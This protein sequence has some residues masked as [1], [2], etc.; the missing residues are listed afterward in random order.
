[1]TRIDLMLGGAVGAILLGLPYIVGLFGPTEAEVRLWGIVSLGLGVGLCILSLALEDREGWMPKIVLALG[2]LAVAMLQILPI[3]LWF[4]FHGRGISD[5]TPPSAFGANWV[6]SIPH[7]A[8][9]AVSI[10]VLFLIFRRKPLPP[11][12]T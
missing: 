5:G 9:F 4:E 3:I 8:L 12:V 2:Y 7:L 6:F 10:A 11:K 1:M